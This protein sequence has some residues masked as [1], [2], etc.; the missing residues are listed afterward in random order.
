[1]LNF[2]QHQVLEAAIRRCHGRR[3][4]MKNAL[5]ADARHWRMIHCIVS[6]L[7]ASSGKMKLLFFHLSERVLSKG[8]YFLEYYCCVRVL[9]DNIGIT[10]FF[11]GMTVFVC[12][13]LLLRADNAT[14]A[15]YQRLKYKL[16]NLTLYR[17]GLFRSKFARLNLFLC[18]S[19][20]A[21]RGR[22]GMS[23]LYPL[24]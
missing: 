20:W 7:C 6:Q 13:A 21:Y 24:N 15:I 4:D 10:I 16:E 5:W 8:V 12:S 1:M 18:A 2:F 23:Q 17:I 19:S 11:S 22:D 14:A 9:W 3:C